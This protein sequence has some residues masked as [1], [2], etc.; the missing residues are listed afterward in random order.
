[1]CAFVNNLNPMSRGISW[2]GKT[3]S[4]FDP[5]SCPQGSGGLE[6]PSPCALMGWYQV[7]QIT[8]CLLGS[9]P[10]SS[11]SPLRSPTLPLHHLRLRV[12]WAFVLAAKHSQSPT[13]SVSDRFLHD[14]WSLLEQEGEAEFRD[15]PWPQPPRPG[16]L[17]EALSPSGVP[18]WVR[19][20]GDDSGDPAAISSPPRPRGSLTSNWIS[21]VPLSRPFFSCSMEPSSVSPPSGHTGKTASGKPAY[22]LTFSICLTNLGNKLSSPYASPLKPSLN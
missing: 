14:Y 11:I 16:F 8:A 2:G 3:G 15:G 10:G 9:G 5:H 18:Q 13:S 1:M 12:F 20:P 17:P 4:D 7:L 22:S 19:L 21:T 6:K